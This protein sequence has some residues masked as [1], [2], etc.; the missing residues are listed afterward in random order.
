MNKSRNW[1]DGLSQCHQQGKAYVLLTVLASA[2]S[3]PRDSGTKMLVT[4]DGSIDTIGGGHLEFHAIKHARMLL[5]Q[6]RN[7]QQIEHYPLSSKLGQCC[8]GATNVLF[9]VFCDHVQ[10]L[11]IFG[12]GHVA[13]A[14]IPI[15]S[16]LPLQIRWIDPR[17]D[18]FKH[19][20]VPDNVSC[21]IDEAPQS[22]LATV[23]ADSWILVMTHSHQLDYAI[24]SAAL[25][26]EHISYVGMIGSDAKA[27]RFKQRLHMHDFQPSQLD[28]LIS[29]VGLPQIVG[30]KPIEV[31]VSIAAQLI[32]KL[33]L[34]LGNGQ[35][36]GQSKSS[37]QL[38]E[39]WRQT[40]EIANLL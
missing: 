16:Q 22:Y 37:Q 20:N 15:V 12:A 3:T 36:D 40:M 33:N 27:R 25:K 7:C 21:E 39:S 32:Q 23:P 10:N 24:V 18:A 1:F 6:N 30:K 19:L 4:E 28:R 8:G 11:M 34:G 38:K 2:G 9:E 31:S 29:P 26:N 14:L 5:T 35:G 17:P 13:Q